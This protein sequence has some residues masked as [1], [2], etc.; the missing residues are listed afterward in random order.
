MSQKWRSIL[1]A[2]FQLLHGNKSRRIE[3]IVDSAC[4]KQDTKDTS[5]SKESSIV[6]KLKKI[7]EYPLI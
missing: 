4:S 5:N 3:T 1:S 2:I 6:K 7:L